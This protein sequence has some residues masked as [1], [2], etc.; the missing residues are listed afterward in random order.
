MKGFSIGY[1]TLKT[2]IGAAI[3]IGLAE[4][5]GLE[6]FTSAGILTILSIQTTKR[7]SLHEVYTRVLASIIGMMM[8][9]LFF[10][11][12]AYQPIVLG[13]MILLFLPVLVMLKITPAFVSSVVIILHI[14][15]TGNFTTGLLMNELSLM[16]IG[17]G[18]GLALNIY[19]PDIKHR[20]EKYRIRIE[21][22]YT[23]IFVE[24]E[25]YLRNGDTSWDGK[26]LVEAVEVL[27]RAKSLAFQDVENHL[28][29]RENLYYMYFDIREQQLEIIERVL[30]KITDLPVIVEQAELVADFLADMSQNINS[31]NTANKYREKLGVVKAEF[32]KLPL[33]TTHEAFVA[34]ASLYQFIEE[35]DL[36]LAKKRDFKGLSPSRKH[37]KKKSNAEN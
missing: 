4:Y 31:G 32:A 27:N 16:L 6:F 10:E 11:G 12:V 1:R 3:S 7:K 33:P 29:R 18:T 5:F 17:F 30:P 14:F 35:M 23:A 15:H 26:E 2:A 9:F 8:A 36:Y 37:F 28:T 22:L 19:M 21:E 25:K 20:L 34:M 24:I 13:C